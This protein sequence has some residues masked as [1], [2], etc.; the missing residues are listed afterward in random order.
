MPS[1]RA[2]KG[3]IDTPRR[4]TT[5]R[6]GGLSAGGL[7]AGGRSVCSQNIAGVFCCSC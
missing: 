7:G 5:V 1:N 4:R 2:R 3:Q 6:H